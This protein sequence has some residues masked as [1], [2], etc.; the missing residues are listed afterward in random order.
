MTH[1]FQ[2][3]NSY[4]TT[5][6]REPC[7]ICGTDKTC[8]T[9]A[10]VFTREDMGKGYNF[11]ATIPSGAC[12]AT[13][14][15]VRKSKNNLALRWEKYKFNGDWMIKPS[16]NY[17]VGNNIFTYERPDDFQEEDALR[18][19]IQFKTQ[20]THGINVFLVVKEN[21]PGVKFHYVLPPMQKPHASP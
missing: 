12:N 10:D 17:T 15:E 8:K 9:V 1:N 2:E 16:G 21:N 5:T 11:L 6:S 18:E 7:Q 4:E 13:V 19:Y 3:M 14:M 20:L